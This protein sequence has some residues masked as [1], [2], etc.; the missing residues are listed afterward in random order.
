MANRGPRLVNPAF[1]L[2][3]VAATDAAGNARKAIRKI[4]LKR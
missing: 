1:A 2:A 4:R 3:T